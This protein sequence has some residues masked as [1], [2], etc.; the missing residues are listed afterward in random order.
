MSC[1]LKH[2]WQ[3]VLLCFCPV[4]SNISDR[5]CCYVLTCFGLSSENASG[6]TLPCLSLCSGGTVPGGILTCFG[7]FAALQCELA[8][9][10]WMIFC[11]VLCERCQVQWR[12]AH[13]SC[14]QK[15]RIGEKRETR[16]S[17]PTF[18]QNDIS[19][20]PRSLYFA[21]PRRSK[22]HF[23]RKMEE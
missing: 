18:L 9:C 23:L 2:F 21:W 11:T 8:C 12:E 6:G 20:Q 19:Q 3:A 1:L 7:M 16:A 14:D 15:S 13:Q 4:C 5:R 17:V 10:V 22:E